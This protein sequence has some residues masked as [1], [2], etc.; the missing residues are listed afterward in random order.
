[1]APEPPSAGA[2][3]EPFEALEREALE[4][5]RG[6][7]YAARDFAHGGGDPEA[8]VR[9]VGAL[10][11]AAMADGGDPPEA[12][13]PRLAWVLTQPLGM[14]YDAEARGAPARAWLRAW[15]WEGVLEQ[16]FQTLGM[17]PWDARRAVSQLDALLAHTATFRAAA[18]HAS[19][20][21][22]ALA[23]WLADD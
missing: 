3:R 19:E 7:A 13:A 8:A 17:A 5:A 23:A 2:M 9:R 4:R 16:T 21:P 6:A 15:R 11:A 22:G 14:V 10:L 12:L 1:E 18:S 20:A